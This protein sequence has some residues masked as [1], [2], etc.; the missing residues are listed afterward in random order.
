[1]KHT[2]TDT[3]IPK[4]KRAKSPAAARDLAKYSRQVSEPGEVRA[5]FPL[6]IGSHLHGA[7]ANF[8]LFSRHAERV[9]LEFFKKAHQ[10]LYTAI[11]LFTVLQK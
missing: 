1:M 9:W 10:R 4:G 6:P 3:A 5:G 11:Y 7:G 8:A 2:M